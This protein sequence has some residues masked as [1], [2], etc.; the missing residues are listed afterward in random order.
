M[1]HDMY[2]VYEVKESWPEYECVMTQE[3]YQCVIA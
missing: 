1:C 2:E 3:M